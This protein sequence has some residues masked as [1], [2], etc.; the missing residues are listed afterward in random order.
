MEWNDQSKLFRTLIPEV[1]TKSVFER[2]ENR[3]EVS[4]F[5]HINCVLLR[6]ACHTARALRDF[7]SAFPKN[8][9]KSSDQAK[10]RNNKS[11]FFS[12]C[13]AA[14][15]TRVWLT[16]GG[17]KQHARTR[18][19]LANTCS[20]HQSPIPDRNPQKPSAAFESFPDHDG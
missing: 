10:K 8:E 11:P 7:P 20:A 5:M 4:F 2:T 3:S 12:C 15:L 14:T 18:H 9:K 1:P 17:K 6:R 19:P 13:S 16:R